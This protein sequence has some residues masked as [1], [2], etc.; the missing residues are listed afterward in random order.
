MIDEAR[1]ASFQALLDRHGAEVA[2]AAADA[3][4]DVMARIDAGASPRA[5]IRRA[6]RRFG[7][8]WTAQ[9]A[10]AF[11]EL[12]G[13]SFSTREI[14]RLRIG[15][16]TLSA[17]LYRQA[18]QVEREA[19]AIISEHA[20]GVHDAR[21]LALRLY[22]GFD[23]RAPKP[24]DGQVS[25]RSVPKAV[26]AIL[27]SSP[28]ARVALER[29]IESGQRQVARTRSPALRAAY[30]AA[31][32]AWQA[33]EARDVLRRRLDLAVREKTRFFAQRI[34]DTELARAYAAGVVERLK[35]DPTAQVVQLQINRAGHKPDI[36]DF[37]AGLDLFGLGPGLYLRAY[38]PVP[39]LHPH[40]RC[41]LRA[42]Q[43]LAPSAPLQIKPGAV[44][45][46]IA[47][48]DPVTR[49]RIFGSRQRGLDAMAAA[50]LAEVDAIMNAARSAEYQLQRIGES[51][52]SAT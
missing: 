39:P 29:L 1:D 13:T 47:G 42:R 43:S 7:R 20:A 14:R 10:A 19:L 16:I 9:M 3:F 8:D 33:G 52:K 48:L 17:K 26:R 12:L 46:F 27:R 22:D 31:L 24:L 25:A 51:G 40:C 23:P 21:A 32:D 2:R 38:A 30:A 50:S 45:R 28:A 36:C 34:A 37:H 15:G 6:L 5:A 41:T 11:S 4:A 18:G 49:S 35:A 44:Q